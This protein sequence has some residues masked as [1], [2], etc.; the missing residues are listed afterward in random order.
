M[1]HKKKTQTTHS[2]IQLHKCTANT[3]NTISFSFS[4]SSATSS[5]SVLAFVFSNW[6]CVCYVSVFG[7]VVYTPTIF[8]NYVLSICVFFLV[9]VW[10]AFRA[11]IKHSICPQRKPV[12]YFSWSSHI[13]R[14]CIKTTFGACDCLLPGLALLEKSVCKCMYERKASCCW[15]AHMFTELTFT[16]S[17]W[18]ENPICLTFNERPWYWYHAVVCPYWP[19]LCSLVF[20]LSISQ[21]PWALFTW[22]QLDLVQRSRWAA[23]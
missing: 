12:L 9:R 17:R 19:V 21:L 13:R 23:N 15:N 2:Y 7:C 16:I 14:G 20:D 5:I 11:T 10:W 22:L 8:F 6:F 18:K 1:Q 3:D 4:L